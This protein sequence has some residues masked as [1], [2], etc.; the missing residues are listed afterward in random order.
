MVSDY[1]EGEPAFK[2]QDRVRI[3]SGQHAGKIAYIVSYPYGQG[4]FGYDV[5]LGDHK[6]VLRDDRP[7]VGY[8]EHEL[9]LP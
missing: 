3:A 9:E 8:W 7:K 1:W 6:Y 2:V 5:V 4:T